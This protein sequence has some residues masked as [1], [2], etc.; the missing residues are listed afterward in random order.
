M[1]DKYTDQSP[2]D[3]YKRGK[4]GKLMHPVTAMELERM[5]KI[6]AKK[7]E[8]ECFRFVRDYYLKGGPMR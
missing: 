1:K 2:L 5:L 7:G 4:A 6:L 8:K 3:Y